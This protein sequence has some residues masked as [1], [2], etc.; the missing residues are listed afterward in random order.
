MAKFQHKTTFRKYFDYKS[1][2]LKWFKTYNNNN[3][4]N[5]NELAKIMLESLSLS[6]L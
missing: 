5:N 3:N 6:V 1:R 2:V 4:N